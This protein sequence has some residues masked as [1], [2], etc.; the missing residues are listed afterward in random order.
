MLSNQQ[1]RELMGKSAFDSARKRFDIKITT[2]KME[3][4][5]YQLISKKQEE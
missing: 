3:S 2:K 5:Y 1:T 4:E